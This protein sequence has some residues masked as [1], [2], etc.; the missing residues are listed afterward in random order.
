ME[1][2]LPCYKPSHKLT[3]AL[4][5]ALGL[6]ACTRVH[7]FFLL[8]SRKK[9]PPALLFRRFEFPTPASQVPKGDVRFA[10]SRQPAAGIDSRFAQSTRPEGLHTRCIP[11]ARSPASESLPASR[12]GFP[13][14]HKSVA[15]KGTNA[16]RSVV[17]AAK[18]PGGAI[19]S[20]L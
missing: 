19:P 13:T 5:K 6:T 4:P 9:C 11:F 7:S 17:P 16:S 12:V 3:R 18:I 15:P 20:Y 10:Q 8:P 1:I 2:F 14:R